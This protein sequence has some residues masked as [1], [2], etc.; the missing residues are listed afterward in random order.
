MPHGSETIYAYYSNRRVSHVAD[1]VLA[2][3][4]FVPIRVFLARTPDASL[5]PW[6]VACITTTVFFCHRFRSRP[7]DENSFFSEWFHSLGYATASY[8]AVYMLL[9]FLVARAF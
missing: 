4:Y 3:M 9:V 2:V 1:V 6:I 8:D 5:H 7:L